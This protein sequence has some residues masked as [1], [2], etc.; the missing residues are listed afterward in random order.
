MADEAFE[1][2]LSTYVVACPDGVN[3]V[4]Y[5]AW[6]ACPADV[7]ALETY[8]ATLSAMTPSV[9]APDEAL[10]FWANLYNALTLLIVLEN[11]PVASIRDI[12][13]ATGDDGQPT[14][15]WRMERVEVEGRRLSLDAIEHAILRRDFAD[16]RVHY[17]I[18]CA[19]ESC[20]NLPAR[21]WSAGTLQA[22]LDAAARAYV[23][24]ERAVS[25]GEDGQVRAAGI[26][27]WF[28]RDFGAGE[29]DVLAHQARFAEPDLAGR[30]RDAGAI[31]A[32]DY[33][34][35]LNDLK[36]G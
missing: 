3:R 18:N 16:P 4:R 11:Y 33:D 12:R 17:A 28:A 6:K 19:S 25:V 15:P 34:W 7:S 21:P 35:A 1:R 27:S 2:L 9:M 29:G 26:Y 22:D 5:G 30:L 8:V 10:S 13:G 23:N 20:P 36:E 24:H 31:A 14:G 32:Y